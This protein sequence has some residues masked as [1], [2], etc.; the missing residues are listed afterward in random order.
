MCSGGDYRK[1]NRFLEEKKVSP[2]SLV[3]RVVLFEESPVVFTSARLSSKCR[4]RLNPG[5]V[6]RRIMTGIFSRGPRG[7]RMNANSVS[8][9]SPSF[10]LRNSLPCP[11]TPWSRYHERSVYQAK[12]R[13]CD[14]Q[15]KTDMV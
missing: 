11:G 4:T 2:D 3:D 1:S 5:A 7:L 12:T 10:Q 15:A 14:E 8:T 13:N 6:C 9:F